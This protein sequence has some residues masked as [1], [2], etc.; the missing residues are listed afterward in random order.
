LYPNCT[1]SISQYEARKGDPLGC[2]AIKVPL[3]EAGMLI[4][5]C[6]GDTLIKLSRIL[7]RHTGSEALWIIT[8]YKLSLQYLSLGKF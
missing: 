5:R 6:F 4:Y 2:K 1:R 3:E 7:P 8:S